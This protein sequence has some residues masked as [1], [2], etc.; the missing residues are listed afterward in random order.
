MM[1]S[2]IIMENALPPVLLMAPHE[3]PVWQVAWA[4][5]KFGN[6]LAT[7]SYDSR[8]LIWKEDKTSWSVIKVHDKHTSSGICPLD[9]FNNTKIL[10]NF[11]TIL[12]TT[13]SF[14]NLVNSIAWAPHELG[15]ILAC[16]S[17][18]GNIS[19]LMF[20]SEGT[21]ETLML[22]DAHSSGVNSVSWAPSTPISSLSQ[23]ISPNSFVKKLA[24]GGSDNLV[25]IWD[26]SDSTKTYELSHTLAAHD[27][28]VRDVAFAPNIGLGS[29]YLASCS[30]DKTVILWSCDIPDP[31]ADP[32]QQKSSE[33]TV[34]SHKPLTS[35][36]F[37][38]VVWRVSWSLSGN[39]LA[40]SCGD[41]KVTLWKETL[42]REWI[43]ITQL[44]ENGTSNP[45][46]SSN[47]S[48]NPVM[49]G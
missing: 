8:V 2:S 37:N 33:K 21:W 40:V 12:S 6:I 49:A 25:K 32:S 18:D 5:P 39:I 20:T 11:N 30:Q 1:L 16:G 44:D 36:P 23:P 27:D 7:C 10:N 29:Q 47:I 45:S 46:E 15:P 35:K 34:W 26:Y 17:S 13:M 38:D 19:F 28:W 42:S 4:H 48:S 41:N 14:T 9:S 43:S 31:N 3:G 22:N 24:S